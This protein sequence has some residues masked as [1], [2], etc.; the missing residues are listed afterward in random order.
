[1]R[2]NKKCPKC[3]NV[4]VV[5][6]PGGMTGKNWLPV[7]LGTAAVDRWVCCAC[8]Y[9]EEWIEQGKLK[10]IKDYWGEGEPSFSQRLKTEE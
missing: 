4:D 9:S 8:G 10:K 6:I 3:G 7:G 1:M 5:E 2:N